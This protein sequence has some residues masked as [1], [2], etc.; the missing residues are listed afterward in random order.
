[1]LPALQTLSG[2]LVPFIATNPSITMLWR[3]TVRLD[4]RSVYSIVNECNASRITCK[5][6]ERWGLHN[7]IVSPNLTLNVIDCILDSL[8]RTA[9]D[10][11]AR[12]WREIKA[13]RRLR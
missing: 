9:T 12:L 8:F 2:K 4:Y 3:D 5:S 6:Q 7:A 1:M 13:D 10:A 11:S